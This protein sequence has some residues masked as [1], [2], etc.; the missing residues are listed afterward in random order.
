MP[1]CITMDWLTRSFGSPIYLTTISAITVTLISRDFTA[2]F[3]LSNL[4]TGGVLKEMDA[5]Q[6]PR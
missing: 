3:L 5:L 2:T 1:G 4:G 6:S